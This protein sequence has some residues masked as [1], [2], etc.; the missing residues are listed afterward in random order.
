MMEEVDFEEIE[1]EVC[2]CARYNPSK[3][4]GKTSEI[5]KRQHDIIAPSICR[6]FSHL[7]IHMKGMCIFPGSAR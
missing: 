3:F 4:T 5:M 7:L 6:R 2:C 1:I